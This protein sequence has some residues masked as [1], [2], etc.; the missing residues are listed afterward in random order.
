M[1]K[2]Y[3]KFRKSKYWENTLLLIV[4]DEHG[5]FYDHVIPPTGVPNPNP[6]DK[7][8]PFPFKF[9]RLGIRVPAIAVSPWLK[10]SVE[11]T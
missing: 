3:E 6:E 1:K 7:S 8:G 2:V 10:N 5:G 11:D 9:N 4:Y